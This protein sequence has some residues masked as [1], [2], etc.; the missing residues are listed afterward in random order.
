MLLESKCLK[1][2]KAMCLF[3]NNVLVTALITVSFILASSL[4][5][6]MK[7]FSSFPFLC[8]EYGKQRNSHLQHLGS[9]K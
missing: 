6:Q 8:F 5:A 1:N 4:I 9:G 3:R 2:L 7:T